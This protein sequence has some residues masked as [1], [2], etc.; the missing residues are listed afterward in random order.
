MQINKKYYII[1]V[2]ILHNY[3]GYN[4]NTYRTDH[5]HFLHK[6]ESTKYVG[7]R[8]PYWVLSSHFTC[9]SDFFSHPAIFTWNLRH[10]NW[11]INK[12]LLLHLGTVWQLYARLMV[13]LLFIF[14][15][16][17]ITFAY[18]ALALHIMYEVLF[19]FN[20]YY[21]WDTVRYAYIK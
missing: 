7:S 4:Y 1:M 18:S 17:F 14:T 5:N 10:Y 9:S 12:S 20:F 2:L 15:L 16:T 19:F 8:D 3:M 11:I 13:Y 6:V 21:F